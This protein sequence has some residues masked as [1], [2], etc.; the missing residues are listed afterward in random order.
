MTNPLIESRDRLIQICRELTAEQATAKL[1]AETWSIAEVVEHLAV[2]ERG[3]MI[4]VKRTLSQPEAS[5]DLLQ[6][7]SDKSV[8]IQTRIT[9]VARKVAAPDFLIPTGRFPQWPGAHLAFEQARS[10]TLEMEAA[11]D[12]KFDSR[13]MPHPVLGS[14]TLRQWFHFTAA[15]TERHTR[16]IEEILAHNDA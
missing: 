5:A 3:S 4:G 9:T 6:E 16:Q 10:N 15:H 12:A 8:L 7:T 2:S 11:A 14:L 13:V 1:G